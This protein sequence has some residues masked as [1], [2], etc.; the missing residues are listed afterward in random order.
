MVFC[1]FA[2]GPVQPA[3][4]A[5]DAQDTLPI[6]VMQVS[7]PPEP[8]PRDSPG[9]PTSEVRSQF[10]RCR[11]KTHPDEA[12]HSDNK[13]PAAPSKPDKDSGTFEKAKEKN[14]KNKHNLDTMEALGII[15]DLHT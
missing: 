15:G 6:D 1:F 8:N 13:E 14:R 4:P 2:T 5:T 11:K 3:V 12:L 9:L 10:H 7:P